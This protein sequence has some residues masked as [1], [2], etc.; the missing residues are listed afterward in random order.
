MKCC[1][2]PGIFVL[3]LLPWI[4]SG[5]EPARV[6]ALDVPG[7]TL[8]DNPLHDP[9]A[10]RVAVFSPRERADDVALPMLYYLPG[11]GGSSED[12]LT[13]GERSPFARLVQQMAADGFALRIAVV[14]ARNRWGGSQYLNSPAQGNY[15]DYVCDEIVPTVEARFAL[16]KGR[17]ARIVAG[18]SSGGYGALM[19]GMKRQKLFGAVIGLSPDSDFEL[20]HRP[21]VEE[22]AVRRVTRAELNAFLSP[23]ADTPLPADG[24]VR[25]MCGLSAAYAPVGKEEP[26]RFEWVW[27]ER[28]EFQPRV[29]RKWLDHDPL[30]L[31]RKNADA[32]AP[33]QRI[34]LDGSAHDEWRFNISARRMFDVLEKRPASVTFYEPP[35]G[36]ADHLAERLQRGVAWVFGRPL[37]EI[38]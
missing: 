9:A 19:L 7:R 12:F 34:Y 27:D 38:R 11:Y 4:A 25:L 32:F 8:A 30:L 10:R 29:W 14:D 2:H 37:V 13:A 17:N 6:V 18:H 22:P 23:V 31:I 15:A 21:F 35:G 36:H 3:L 26:G 24:T 5:N 16:A 1:A 20:T 33:D 28:G